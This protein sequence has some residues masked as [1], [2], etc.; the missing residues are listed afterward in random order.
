MFDINAV[1]NAA[2]SQAIHNAIAP[3][4][5]RVN[6][7]THRI[8][9]LEEANT[10]LA[11]LCNK[12]NLRIDEETVR[13][14]LNHDKLVERVSEAHI[15][16]QALDAVVLNHTKA[17]SPNDLLNRDAVADVVR[18]LWSDEFESEV[19][20]IAERT[21]DDYDFEDKIRRAVRDHDFSDAVEEVLNDYDLSD[22][23]EEVLDDRLDDKM[24]EAID[25]IDFDAKVRDVLRTARIDISL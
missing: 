4:N 15:K 12:Q 20:D 8:N 10:I 3:F 11:D 14:S 16:L 18:D 21:V 19:R 9:E 23:I 6:A 24:S 13:L 1:I 7:L 2:I 5:D 25:D 17:A 22:K